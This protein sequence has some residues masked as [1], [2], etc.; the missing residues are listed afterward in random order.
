M[1]QPQIAQQIQQL[2]NSQGQQ[3][4]SKFSSNLLDDFDYSDEEASPRVQNNPSNSD[5]IEIHAQ[6]LDSL[7]VIMSTERGIQQLKQSGQISD[8]QIQELQILLSA[9]QSQSTQ[10]FNNHQVSP[11]VNNYGATGSAIISNLEHSDP[12][13]LFPL[14]H[15]TH[16]T[17]DMSQPPPM[18]VSHI[19]PWNQSSSSQIQGSMLQ[20]TPL[21]DISME[22]GRDDN[23]S[24]IEVIDDRDGGWNERGSRDKSGRR[25]KDKDGRRNRRT[26]SRSRSRSRDR[27]RSK[28]SRRDRRYSKRFTW[29]GHS[30]FLVKISTNLHLNALI[31]LHE[32]KSFIF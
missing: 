19:N 7:S 20:N 24:D 10:P 26:G 2:L 32:T 8:G 18:S 6:L 11:Q 9:R 4:T 3:D 31:L 27:D 28:R 22:A 13:M 1:D 12:H 17:I 5:K 23:M 21:I 14:G 29:L 16:H 25:N 15:P 30:S